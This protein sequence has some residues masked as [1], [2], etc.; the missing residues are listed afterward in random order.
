MKSTNYR[1]KATTYDIEI[2]SLPN[3]SFGKLI[4]ET[5]ANSRK[6]ILVDEHTH[7]DCLEYLLTTFTELADAEV[8]L[9][10]C[11]EENKVMEVCFQV[12][13][14]LSEY[15]ISR[16]DLVINLG[17][18]VVTDMGGF[19]ASVYKRGI[20]FIN[21]PTSLLA[22][23]DA[24]VGGKTGIDL[25]RHKNQLGVF[26]DPVAL[27]IDPAFLQTLPEIEWMNGFAEM[28]KH[29]LIAD[30]KHWNDLRTFNPQHGIDREL[31]LRSVEIK[32]DIVKAD[33]RE[34]NERKKLNF[35]H[36]F[37][38]ALEGFLLHTPDAISHGHAVAL[39][40]L[41]ESFVSKEKKMLSNLEFEEIAQFLAGIYHIPPVK[42]ESFDAI[43]ELMLNDK[44]NDS[45]QILAA[46]IT[47]IG[48]C[49]V[50]VPLNRMEIMTALY[51]LVNLTEK[52]VKLN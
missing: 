46:L 15:A 26:S 30:K 17:G 21:I 19:I 11:G 7:D 44:K 12:W 3:S 50:N 16:K 42:E 29:G 5:Y 38:H 45:E 33:P 41:C 18:G 10:P 34:Q 14:A 40:M 8:M 52:Q 23:V 20:D 9:L 31:I 4:A 32:N 36:T 51:W 6:I 47:E 1:L 43:Y 49:E 37:G 48:A 13:E 39:G 2:A 35:G 28:F 25:G 24:S 22:M 27:F